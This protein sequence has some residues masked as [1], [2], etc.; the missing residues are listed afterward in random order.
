MIHSL[1]ETNLNFYPNMKSSFYEVPAPLAVFTADGRIEEA[2]PA[3]DTL[4]QTDLRTGNRTEAF[5]A[6]IGEEAFEREVERSRRAHASGEVTVSELVIGIESSGMHYEVTRQ[7]IHA[8]PDATPR[9]LAI[10]YDVSGYVWS[11]DELRHRLKRVESNHRRIARE[12]YGMVRE[13]QEALEHFVDTI[14]PKA[15]DGLAHHFGKEPASWA[16]TLELR[17]Q[18]L[19]RMLRPLAQEIDENPSEGN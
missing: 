2:N 16:E 13:A 1:T 7:L 11:Y 8:E 19:Q 17:L 10:F 12:T 15:G 6:Q 9:V 5:A 4:F 3:W 18:H 14:L